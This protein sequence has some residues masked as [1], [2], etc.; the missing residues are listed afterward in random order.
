M[1]ANSLPK[2]QRFIL[3]RGLPPEAAAEAAGLF[4]LILA[5]DAGVLLLH[6]LNR[7]SEWNTRLFDLDVE[8]NL[9]TWLGAIQFFGVAVCA[10]LLSRS[11]T[12]R[13]ALAWRVVA[14]LFVFLSLDEIAQLHEEIVDRVATSPTGDA[15]FWPFFYAPLGAAVLAALWVLL[16]DVRLYVGSALLVV[17]SL[18][19]LAASVFLDAAATQFVDEPWL[20]EPE[21]V[22]EE[23]AELLGSG[24]L[25]VLLLGI[26]LARR[27]RM[28][29]T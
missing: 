16:D 17:V 27:E 12:G 21:L 11:A 20:Y 9:P 26:F 22:L 19:L 8:S 15:W 29:S 23:G 28:P 3:W 25:I 5:A 14:L 10:A 4:A 18:G 2:W 7:A 13:R 1:E 6:V 24:I